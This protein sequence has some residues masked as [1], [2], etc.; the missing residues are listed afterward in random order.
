LVGGWAFQCRDFSDDHQAIVDIYI[1]GDVIGLDSVLRPRTLEKV[2]AL[3][4]I[5]AEVIDPE[6][7]LTDLMTFRAMA[8]YIA[9]LLGQ[10][11]R[12]TDSVLAAISSLDA[13]GKMATMVLDF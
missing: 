6:G 4:S 13:R 9:W 2:M 5:A 11:Q 7:A 12:R 3:T 10:R 8:L 1:P